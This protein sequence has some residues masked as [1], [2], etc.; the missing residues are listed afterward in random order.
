MWDLVEEGDLSWADHQ[1][2]QNERVSI[3]LTAPAT[4][5]PQAGAQNAKVKEVLCRDYNSRGGCRQRG[6]HVEE[7]IRLMHWCAFCDSVSRQC[8]HSVF[9]CN[10][11]R[12]Q[13]NPMHQQFEHNPQQQSWRYNNQQY[14]MYAPPPQFPKN[15]QQAPRPM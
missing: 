6:H 1:L 10:N 3:A 12:M 9:A 4:G 11:K 7:N 8:P 13:S 15:G 2:I 5:A 14:N